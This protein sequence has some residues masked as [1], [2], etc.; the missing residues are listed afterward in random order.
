LTEKIP[1]WACP[2]AGSEAIRERTFL[3]RD[4][5][6]PGL[7]LV[8][9]AVMARIGSFSMGYVIFR[10]T[11]DVERLEFPMA[12][13]TA[14]GSMALAESGAGKE[15]WRWRIFSIGGMIG[16]LFGL[17][18][19]AVPAI[20][21]T[22]M[23]E[24]F[25]ILP[26]PFFDATDEIGNILPCSMLGLSTNLGVLFTGFI[27][28]FWV[29]VGM[30][31]GSIAS[32]VIVNPLL[33]KYTDIMKSWSQ[34]MSAIPTSTA[35]RMDFWIPFIIGFSVLVAFMG[36]WKTIMSFKG[37]GGT[38]TTI[39]KT[40]PP[41]RG[42][43]PIWLALLGYYIITIFYMWLILVL[44]PG[45]PLWILAFFG[46]VLSPLLSYIN[47]RMVGITG[48]YG[49][50]GFPYLF[51]Y[52]VVLSGY[53]GAAIWFAP[54]IAPPGG[55]SG[56]KMAE[57]TRTK[58]A[59][60]IKLSFTALG[61]TTVFSFV[62]WHLIWRMGPIPSS[63]YPYIN[64]F[65]PMH[66]I[67]KSLWA[68][69]YLEGGPKFMLESITR[70]ELIL[71]GFG[72][73]L[74]I[75][76]LLTLFKIPIT[77][78]YGIVAGIAPLPHEVIPMFLGALLARFYLGKKFEGYETFRRK[79]APVFLAG[80]GCGMGLVGMASIALVLIAKTVTALIF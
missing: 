76:I 61:I 80:F 12:H 43:C 66:A 44:V 48:G 18:Y 39:R 70:W 60:L 10:Y 24:P 57:L 29:V 20:T 4:W 19:V 45:F 14:Q 37:K 9:N 5:F 21:G 23:V 17:I 79:Y 3:H 54:A 73:G 16:L 68:T 22:M 31:V 56:F 1:T 49:G 55:P 11:S 52:L 47:G 42:D 30:F 46:F 32:G 28:P 36:I 13:I 71:S 74:V 2:P 7:L 63:A 53:K 15:T 75:L 77:F 65:W 69:L 62:F 64:K 25:M 67:M 38:Q 78:F 27:L 51:E 35:T 41:G 26:I 58:F 50:V 6:I 59:S 34:G 72:S 8:V 40:P 33:Y